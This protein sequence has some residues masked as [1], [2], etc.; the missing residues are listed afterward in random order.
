[1][2]KRQPIALAAVAFLPKSAAA[3]LL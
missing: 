1:M 2:Q 3:K